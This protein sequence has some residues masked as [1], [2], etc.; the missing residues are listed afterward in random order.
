MK[1]GKLPS[2]GACSVVANWF[3]GTVIWADALP[4][5]PRVSRLPR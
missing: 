1:Q 5:I 3:L 2:L 4:G